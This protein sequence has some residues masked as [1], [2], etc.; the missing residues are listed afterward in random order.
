MDME[1]DLEELL[2]EFSSL[3]DPS[4]DQEPPEEP[5]AEVLPA[6]PEEPEEAVYTLHRCR[7]A[8]PQ[9]LMRSQSYIQFGTYE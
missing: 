1:Y 4:P 7:E 6:A 3:N 2:R 9:L 8:F 5:A